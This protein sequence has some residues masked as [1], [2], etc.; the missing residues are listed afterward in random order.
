MPNNMRASKGQ[1][2]KPG[3]RGVE[4]DKGGENRKDKLNHVVEEKFELHQ[5]FHIFDWNSYFFQEEEQR[6]IRGG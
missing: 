5:H 3:E 6:K 1:L 4:D 2:S